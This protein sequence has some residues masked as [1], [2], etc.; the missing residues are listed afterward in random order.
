MICDNCGHKNDTDAKFCEKCGSNLNKSSLHNSTKILIVIVIV[1]V[2][3]LGVA[4]GYILFSKNNPQNTLTVVNNSSAANNTTSNSSNSPQTTS[5]SNGGTNANSNQGNN[6]SGN[7]YIS[8]S[9]AVNIALNSYPGTLI[10]VDL[11]ESGTDH[12]YYLVVIQ[13][14]NGIQEMVDVNAITGQIVGES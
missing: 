1:L 2:A 4:G 7:N 13:Q 11:Q 5:S 9:Q 12:P 6:N 3:G 8:S 14:S 10:H